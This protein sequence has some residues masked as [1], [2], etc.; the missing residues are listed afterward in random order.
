MISDGQDGANMLI[1]PDDHNTACL[2]INLAQAINIMAII[3]MEHLLIISQPIFALG[4]P[5][6]IWQFRDRSITLLENRIA[7]NQRVDICAFG[8]VFLHR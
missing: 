1:R 8:R 2:T 5:Q 4:R 6:V 7:I 3:C